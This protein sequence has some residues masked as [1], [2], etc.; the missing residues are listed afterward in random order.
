MHTTQLMRLNIYQTLA[1]NKYTRKGVDI[2]K[3]WYKI[4]IFSKNIDKWRIAK[5]VF[6]GRVTSKKD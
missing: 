6:P 3:S 1:L 4:I 2:A 5:I